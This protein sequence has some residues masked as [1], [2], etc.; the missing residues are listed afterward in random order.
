MQLKKKTDVFNLMDTNGRRSDI[1]NA[2]GIYLS[3]LQQLEKSDD[4]EWKKFPDSLN[5]YKFYKSS[6][7]IT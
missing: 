5:Q 4:P 2:Y 3:I 6:G 1:I 7:S